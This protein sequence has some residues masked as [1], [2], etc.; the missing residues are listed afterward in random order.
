MFTLHSSGSYKQLKPYADSNNSPLCWGMTC[1]WTVA[2]DAGSVLNPIFFGS[3]SFTSSNS[4]TAITIDSRD[5][6]ANWFM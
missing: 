1:S 5:Y 4:L 6:N 3:P 2:T